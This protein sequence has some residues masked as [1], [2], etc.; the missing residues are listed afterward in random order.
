M[1][2]SKDPGTV[3][4]VLQEGT[5]LFLFIPMENLVVN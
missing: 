5:S 1:F 3:A 2:T 4:D